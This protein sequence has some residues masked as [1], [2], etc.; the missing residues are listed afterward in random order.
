MCFASVEGDFMGFVR[1]TF[2]RGDDKRLTLA[3]IST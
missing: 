3:F 2:F 1:H